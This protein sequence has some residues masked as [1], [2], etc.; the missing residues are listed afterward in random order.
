MKVSCDTNVFSQRVGAVMKR[1]PLML[2]TSNDE[3]SENKK[4]QSSI[5]DTGYLCLFID[6]LFDSANG[7][8]IKPVA[9]KELR[10]A[11]TFNS[12]H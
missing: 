5:E 10:S 6:N 3:C 2:N 12:A 9:G 8:K 1:L 7:N 4:V 11:I